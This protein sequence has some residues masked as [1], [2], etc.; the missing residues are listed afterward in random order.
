M[1]FNA[2]LSGSC[3]LWLSLCV[4]LF[5]RL[6]G[7]TN[8]LL[9]FASFRQTYTA[10][11]ARNF[12]RHGMQI[13]SPRLDIIGIQNISEFPIYPAC[14]AVLY[15]IFGEYEFLG[16]LFSIACGLG[17]I[18]YLYKLGVL[19]WSRLAGTLA[20]L[21]FAI[22]PMAVYYTRTYQMD[23]LMLVC[24]IASIYYLYRWYEIQR[25][26]LFILAVFFFGLALLI[27]IP[28]L[29]LFLPMAYIFYLRFKHLQRTSLHS[30]WKDASVL[31][32]FSSG[33]VFV[34]L[35]ILPAFFW[36]FIL[37]EIQP[38]PDSFVGPE[39]SILGRLLKPEAL[40][41]R[42]FILLKWKTI[43]TL[44]LTRLLEYH[45]TFGGTLILLCWAIYAIRRRLQKHGL[46]RQYNVEPSDL[47]GHNSMLWLCAW[48][49]VGIV[50]F[51]LAFP[52]FNSLHEYYQ[53]PMLAPATLLIGFAI[54]ELWIHRQQDKF[55]KTLNYIAM[56]A[57]ILILPYSIFRL[58]SRLKVN[59]E[60]LEI[61]RQVRNLNPEGRFI[62]VMDDLPRPEIFYYAGVRGYIL[63]VFAHAGEFPSISAETFQLMARE[64]I[65]G[66][67][68]L[69]IALLVVMPEKLHS[70]ALPFHK[71]F[72]ANCPL[73]WR[74]D[75][76]GAHT[77]TARAIYGLNCNGWP[78]VG[79]ISPQP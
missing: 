43:R 58:H 33:V 23:A 20:G 74:P 31:R 18:V 35:A 34:V 77:V 6:P 45:L 25:I 36:Y 21:S 26:Y 30:F 38:D 5:M 11:I 62:V 17:C 59:H 24:S 49:C 63:P 32:L 8:P 2:F 54:Q 65:I 37:P 73:L 39:N 22:L 64:S 55:V 60:F 27:K 66:Y 4:A 47:R 68:K 70:L 44:F 50:G 52:V 7:L 78:E 40:L 42:V 72:I 12:Y 71:E 56:L 15:H 3:G 51:M 67:Q 41:L 61:T 29:Y 53:L 57:G 48:W 9:D 19:F 28:T 75:L 46:R 76:P 10:M 79:S 69:N 14:I 16:R 1:K 13:L